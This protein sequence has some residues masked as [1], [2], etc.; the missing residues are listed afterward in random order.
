MYYTLIQCMLVAGVGIFRCH[1]CGHLDPRYDYN[2]KMQIWSSNHCPFSEP[3]QAIL[4][5][6]LFGMNICVPDVITAHY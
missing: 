2:I 1:V 4:V 5:I 6:P 3:M